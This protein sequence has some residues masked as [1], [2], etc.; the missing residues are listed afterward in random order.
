MKMT[1]RKLNGKWVEIDSI[2]CVEEESGCLLITCADMPDFG[3][4][5]RPQN[6]RIVEY[7]QR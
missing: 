7:D 6:W 3:V 5:Y 2:C 1:E 4:R